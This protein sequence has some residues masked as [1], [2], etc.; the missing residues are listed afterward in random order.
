MAK[1]ASLYA[2]VLVQSLNGASEKEQKEIAIRFKSLLKKRGDLRHVS[3]ILQEFLK[4]W[5]ERKGKIARVITAHELPSS[6]V[7]SMKSVLK[8]KGYQVKEE[9][10]ENLIGGAAV[11][12]GNEYLFDNTARGRLQKLKTL[13]KL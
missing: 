6:F 10:N 9:Q 11:F 2:K 3:S 4:L 5:E 8:K 1:K 7:S 13:V 12:L